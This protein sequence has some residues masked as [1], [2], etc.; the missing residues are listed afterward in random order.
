MTVEKFRQFIDY[1]VKHD[2]IFVSP[3]D[4]QNGLDPGKNSTFSLLL[5]DGY[6]NNNLA[7][8]ILKEYNI[9][10]LFFISSNHIKQ[11]KCFWWDV[12][13]RQRN[14]SRLQNR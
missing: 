8:P 2:Y 7:L 10:A 14:K 13:Y 6:Y 12:V 4:I 9:P 5:K 1:Y 3:D 11:N